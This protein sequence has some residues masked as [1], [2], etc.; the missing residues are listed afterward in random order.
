MAI[1]LQTATLSTNL[2]EEVVLA[3]ASRQANS[4]A[5]VTSYKIMTTLAAVLIQIASVAARAAMVKSMA[6]AYSVLFPRVYPCT[7]P[8]MVQFVP[9]EIHP[10]KY[11]GTEH[12]ETFQHCM[13]SCTYSGRTPTISFNRSHIL[14]YISKL[15][16]LS[17]LILS[18]KNRRAKSRLL[19]LIQVKHYENDLYYHVANE[20]KSWLGFVKYVLVSSK[21]IRIIYYRIHF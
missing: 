5:V 20:E 2:P 1:E 9:Q 8:E 4:I 3:L 16:L 19:R 6:A 13:R 15:F 12:S 14:L 10:Y 11:E 18:Q 17:N 7:P 21:I